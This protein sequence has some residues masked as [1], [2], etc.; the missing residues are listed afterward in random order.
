MTEVLVEKLV[1]ISNY[2]QLLPI[3]VQIYSSRTILTFSASFIKYL[4]CI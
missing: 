3:G 1:I 4:L 2:W